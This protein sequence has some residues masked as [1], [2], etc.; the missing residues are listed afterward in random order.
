MSDTNF[1]YVV[2]GV[3]VFFFLLIAIYLFLWIK[4]ALKIVYISKHED[5][6]VQSMKSNP[7]RLHRSV[8]LLMAKM[9][10][11][12]YNEVLPEKLTLIGNY[13]RFVFDD[14]TQRDKM[15]DLLQETVRKSLGKNDDTHLAERTEMFIE[16][17]KYGKR[18][19]EKSRLAH[20]LS[21]VTRFLGKL[22]KHSFYSSLSCQDLAVALS[23]QLNQFQRRY[24]SYLLFR[25]AIVDDSVNALEKIELLSLCVNGLKMPKDEF[26]DMCD[27]WKNN[28]LNDWFQNN[29]QVYNP[30]V[31]LNSDDLLN[32]FDA[33]DLSA[34]ENT[35]CPSLSLKSLY[36]WVFVLFFNMAV[37]VF[38]GITEL[39][40]D[41]PEII[42]VFFII[43]LGIALV[44]K[45][46]T[47]EIP[48][49]EKYGTIFMHGDMDVSIKCLTLYGL[50]ILLFIIISCL[51]IPSF[52]YSSAD[53]HYESEKVLV[54]TVL[55]G[56]RQTTHHRKHGGTYHNYYFSFP[57]IEINS[58]HPDSVRTLQPEDKKLL[59]TLDKLTFSFFKGGNQSVSKIMVSNRIYKTYEVHDEITIS[60]R[61][62][63]YG[64][65]IYC[66]ID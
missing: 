6:I 55:T 7:L 25:I 52:L 5:A 60:V 34:T 16:G 46:G 38:M 12:D 22:D 63:F 49:F 18:S 62:G 43:L 41:I 21:G 2:Y 8:V 36:R 14:K 3:F 59:T 15:F 44:Y 31:S 57:T 26:D 17:M 30:S 42:A 28:Q 24:I 65:N 40:I 37:I 39:V 48:Y 27:A 51:S 64:K 32:V 56:K 1:R 23:R 19:T 9:L 54:H 33:Q 29:I 58:I 10:R 35:V 20:G 61:K 45:V 11:T 47:S 13:I 53:S 50:T 66:D 4:E